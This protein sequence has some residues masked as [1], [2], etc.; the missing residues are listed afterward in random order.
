MTR[1]RCGVAI[2]PHFDPAVE[3]VALTRVRPPCLYPDSGEVQLV[4]P[5]PSG[6]TGC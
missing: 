1:S 6:T 2:F 5:D 4:Q 3:R